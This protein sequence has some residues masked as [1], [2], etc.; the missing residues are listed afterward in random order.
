LKVGGG[1][2]QLL[3]GEEDIEK[4]LLRLMRRGY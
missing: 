4:G 2:S 3:G 1:R